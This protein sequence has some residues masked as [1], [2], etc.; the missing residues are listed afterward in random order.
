MYS[1]S[2]EI[3]HQWY[4]AAVLF[5]EV[6]QFLISYATATLCGASVVN[7]TLYILNV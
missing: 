5:I 6:S 3:V 1:V 4:I 2:V 7:N